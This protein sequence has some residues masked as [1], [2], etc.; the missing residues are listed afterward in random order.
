MEKPASPKK[1]QNAVVVE[2]SEEE[3]RA[4]IE[5]RRQRNQNRRVATKLGDG[6]ITSIFKTKVLMSIYLRRSE[7]EAGHVGHGVR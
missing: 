7:S 4:R 2:E 1:N 3:R 5:A 6:N